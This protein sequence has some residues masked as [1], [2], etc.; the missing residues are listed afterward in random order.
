MSFGFIEEWNE[1]RIH[2]AFIQVLSGMESPGGWTPRRDKG[3][4]APFSLLAGQF[5]VTCQLSLREFI[6]CA[7]HEPY[8]TIAL[9]LNNDLSLVL[10]ADYWLV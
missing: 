4:G 7:W 2:S 6:G 3:R 9:P 10:G 5:K 8:S 1:L